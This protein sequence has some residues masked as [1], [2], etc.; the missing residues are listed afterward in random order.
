[1]LRI[2]YPALAILPILLVLVFRIAVGRPRAALVVLA[3]GCVLV[4]FV[5]AIALKLGGFARLRLL[6]WGIF[7]AFPLGALGI[8]WIARR[9]G[10]LVPIALV[11]AAC[12]VLGV[13]GYAFHLEPKRL[14]VTHHTIVTDRVD[15]PLRIALVADLQTDDIGEHERR[16]MRAVRESMPDVVLLAGDYLQCRT[17]ASTQRQRPMFRELFHQPPLRAPLGVHAIA[18]NCEIGW[19]WTMLFDGT[20]VDAYE[21]TTTVDLGP[22]SLTCLSFADGLRGTPVARPDERFHVALSHLPDYALY[23][24]VHADLLLAGHC[25]GGQVRVPF[26]GPPIKL[27]AIPRDWT[28]GLVDL[29]DGRKLI[30]SRGVGMERGQ[31]PRLRFLCRPQVVVIDLVP[32]S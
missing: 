7:A 14:E 8:A 28:E 9:R 25:H 3:T 24:N 17:M 29:P 20:G 4:P 30:V 31:A 11:A 18:G 5:L 19:S 32:A 15:E 12:V 10:K 21:E 1:M 23:D 16:A 13:Y 6:A 22:I 26:F 2:D 27:S